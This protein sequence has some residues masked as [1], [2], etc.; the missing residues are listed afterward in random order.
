M[1]FG[2]YIPITQTTN[3]NISNEHTHTAVDNGTK[4]SFLLSFCCHVNVVWVNLFNELFTYV[5]QISDS[6]DCKKPE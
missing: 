2:L 4:V 5:N 3:R 1:L 6:G